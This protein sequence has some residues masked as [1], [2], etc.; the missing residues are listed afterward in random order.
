MKEIQ[1]ASILASIRGIRAYELLP[2]EQ[3][4]AKPYISGTESLERFW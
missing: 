1:I 3:F 4:E 2:G